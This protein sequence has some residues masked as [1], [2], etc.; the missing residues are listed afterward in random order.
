M[1]P[2]EEE[3]IVRTLGT[4][5][6]TD[7]A[8]EDEIVLEIIAQSRETVVWIDVVGAKE[9]VR[10]PGTGVWTDVVGEE[11]IVPIAEIVLGIIARSQGAVW[12]DA[13]GEDEI[14]REIIVRNPEHVSI[15]ADAI[16]E[17]AHSLG[18]VAIAA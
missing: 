10:N 17:T 9:I 11:D 13:V 3:E 12:I 16:I 6:W 5:V 18:T 14:V 8:E 1:D 7:A 4:V 2:V 15:A